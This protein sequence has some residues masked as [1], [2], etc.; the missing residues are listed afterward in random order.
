MLDQ[1]TMAKYKVL[2]GT[3]RFAQSAKSKEWVARLK[4]YVRFNY[5]THKALNLCKFS[6]YEPKK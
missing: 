6:C 4:N 5:F 1:Q 3:P 2:K